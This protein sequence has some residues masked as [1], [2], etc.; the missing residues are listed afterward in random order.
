MMDS[1]ENLGDY[2]VFFAPDDVLI[3][4]DKQIIISPIAT[5]WNDFGF[6]INCRFIVTNT[7]GFYE[8]E[9]YIGFVLP[10]ASTDEVGRKKLLH[11]EY[12]L[13]KLLDEKGATSDRGIDAAQMPPFF[14]MLPTQ[15]DY[16]ELISQLGVEVA[17]DILHSICDLLAYKDEDVRWYT[18]AVASK[19]FSLAFMRNSETYFTYHNADSILQGVEF[20]AIGE[21]AQSLRLTYQ[22]DGFE[23]KH[24]INLQYDSNSILPRRVSVLIGKNGV[25]K[26]QGLK[27]FI[28]AAMQ[29]TDP[30]I[31]LTEN[32]YRPKISRLLAIASPGETNT[33]LPP[34][35]KNQKLAYK[36]MTLTRGAK[37]RIGRS[38]K[39]LLVTL[40]RI[41]EQF[42]GGKS[43]WDI[44]IS[45]VA[46]FVPI[47]E[48]YLKDRQGKMVPLLDFRRFLGEQRQLE[49]WGGL[50]P[51]AEPRRKAGPNY[52][53][54]S[55]GQIT[56]IKFALACCVCIENGSFVLLD[57]PET[58]M[59][60]NMIGDF[61]M[62]LDTLL[63]E[64]GSLALIATHSPYF[65]REVSR[66][67][68]HILKHV[69]GYIDTQSPR[70]RTFGADVESISQFIFSEDVDGRL[71]D[72][73]IGKSAGKSFAEIEEQLG[74]ELSMS[75]LMTIKDRLE[76]EEA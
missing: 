9:L 33:S 1:N 20:E 76:N 8:G 52:H 49:T 75:A 68:V 72:K 34:E 11:D 57:E 71:V 38:F 62:L 59:H 16:R 18:E 7:G 50:L 5:N 44:F 58:H 35:R 66:E 31:S 54:L 32:G 61:M 27:Q 28:R 3:P 53:S 55:S 6:Q 40:A 42:V 48:L 63:E 17:N 14:T 19:V 43:R 46:A 74:S 30:S 26:S 69:D 24:E 29:I 10:R 65:V 45:T 51:S 67:Q 25:G 21:L 37:T 47:K 39:D 2:H 15:Q 56:F 41:D 73:I 70:L 12:T 64:T 4:L 36:R 22:L 13:P 60:P 23:N